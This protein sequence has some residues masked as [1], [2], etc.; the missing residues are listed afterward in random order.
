L[1]ARNFSPREDTSSGYRLVVGDRVGIGRHEVLRYCSLWKAL[2]MKSDVERAE[3]NRLRF[4]GVEYMHAIDN[5]QLSRDHT[6]GVVVALA[7]KHSD[8]VLSQPKHLFS[9]EQS[10]AKVYPVAVA[11]VTC[12]NYEVDTLV[13]CEI[14]KAVTARR[15]A[16]LRRFAGAPSY[17]LSPRNGLSMCRSEA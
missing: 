17:S 3:L 9:E 10:R 5:G 11:N 8:A 7:N 14:T 1:L 2:T 6:G 16:P 13:D 12:K 4:A 15:V